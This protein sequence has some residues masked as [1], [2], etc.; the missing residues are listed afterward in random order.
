[1]RRNV[2]TALCLIFLLG[3]CVSNAQ[4]RKWTDKSGKTTQTSVVSAKPDHPKAKTFTEQE[5]RK[6]LKDFEAVNGRCTQDT[7]EMVRLI[8]GTPIK[9]THFEQCTSLEQA[10]T[11]IKKVFP[12]HGLVTY[13][14]EHGFI[15]GGVSVKHGF[16]IYSVD[17]LLSFTAYGGKPAAVVFF[18]EKQ[19]LERIQNTVQ[20][21]PHGKYVDVNRVLIGTE[22]P[23]A[24]PTKPQGRSQ[25]S[26]LND[27]MHR[28]RFTPAGA[29]QKDWQTTLELADDGTG[30]LI[31]A[32][33]RSACR[34]MVEKEQFILDFAGWG[35]KTCEVLD[36]N[37][38]VEM[39]EK[40]MK[41]SRMKSGQTK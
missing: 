1:M 26:V 30:T 41:W 11:A 37:T 29:W 22:K 25:V 15:S 14:A 21:A 28:I 6:A 12:E 40:T 13:W 18:D 9:L 17:P 16:I 39:P 27:K 36:G 8:L 33:F 19:T 20:S 35:K 38:F 4:E 32:G 3:F 34:W 5:I 24:E 2:L 10:V 31:I 7:P 23:K